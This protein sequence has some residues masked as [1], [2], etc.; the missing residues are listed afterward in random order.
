MRRLMKSAGKQSLK[1]VRLVD[2]GPIQQA[3]ISLGDLTVLVGPQATGKS[4]FL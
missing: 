3:D 2:V 1:R 4:L